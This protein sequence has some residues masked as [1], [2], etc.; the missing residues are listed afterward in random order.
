MISTKKSPA[1]PET[2]IKIGNA[3]VRSKIEY[4]ATVYG[5]AAKTHIQKLD[6][7]QNAYLRTAGRYIKTTPIN[8]I[9]ADTGQ[10]PMN[11]R[12][13]ELTLKE[14]IRFKYFNDPNFR[15]T[16]KA[17]D[18]DK[19]NGTWITKTTIEYIEVLHQLQCQ[20]KQMIQKM[21]KYEQRGIRVE[22]EIDRNLGKKDNTAAHVWKTRTIDLLRTKYKNHK[23]IYTDASKTKEGVAIAV[24][25]L[26]E[27]RIIDETINNNFC[28]T[29]AELLAISKACIWI[30]HNN[31][32]KAVILTDA[33]SACVALQDPKNV[34]NNYIVQ[35]IYDCIQSKNQEIVIQW[36]PSH[37]GLN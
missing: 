2:M 18:E 35:Q 19:D 11:L 37:I 23:H 31:F 13:E 27:K 22:T 29:N 6:T 16:G 14:S 26:E 36:V 32:E 15:F 10:K 7:I 24:V 1:S 4:G 3:I 34:M 21:R 28:I 5:G 9:L 12:I 20:D 33:K 25:D 30:R 8:V 17:L